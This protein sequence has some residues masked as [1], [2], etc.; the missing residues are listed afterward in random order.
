MVYLDCC[1]SV[2]IPYICKP[3]NTDQAELFRFKIATNQS[4]NQKSRCF[5][6]RAFFLPFAELRK[7]T[8]TG[9]Q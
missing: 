6:I 8:I 9:G 5:Y 7:K 2:L 4:L 3:I 1:Q